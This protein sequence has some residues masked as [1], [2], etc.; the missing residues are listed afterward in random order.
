MWPA[1]AQLADGLAAFE[2]GDYSV[3]EKLLA[4]LDD[5]QA[6][7]FL[8]LSQAGAGHCGE[9]EAA[10]RQSFESSRDPRLRR[11]TGLGLTR[12]LIAAER[13]LDAASPLATL[14]A[15]FPDNADV[16]YES[17][18]LHLKAWNGAVERMFERAP[19]SFRVNQL[20]AEIFEIQG[21]FD[22]AIAEYRKAIEKSPQ[23]LNLHYR[24]GR[25]LLLRSH[26]AAALDE[27]RR[28]FEAELGLNPYDAVAEYQ[29][30]QILEARQDSA[31]A[32]KRLERAIE[33]NPDFAEA[34]IALARYRTRQNESAEAARLLERAVELQPQSEGAWYALMTA[35]RNAGRREDAVRAKQRLDELQQSPEGEFADFL[36]RIGEPAAP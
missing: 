1:A 22:E 25:A 29:I 20:S 5:P 13:W 2:R 9:A 7:A 26:E 15:A 18:R 27:A 14:E 16:L 21:R 33:I 23:T 17:A 35:Y 19:A 8:A 30:A 11:L 3:A 12:C 28:A 24:L 31:G 36:R 6:R 32:A 34:L 10:L 4:G